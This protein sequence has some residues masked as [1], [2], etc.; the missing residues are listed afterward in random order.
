M[1]ISMNNTRK[2]IAALVFLTGFTAQAQVTLQNF[3]S[4]VGANTFFHGSWEATG[5]T[6]GT[7]SPNSQFVQGSGVYDF[8]GSAPIIPTNS[9]DSKIEFF[10]SSPV[11]IGPN[12]QLSVTAQ[13]LSGNV[14]TSFAV[15][16]FDT[17][18]K[19]ASASFATS[20]FNGGNYATATLSLTFQSGFNSS[21]IDSMIISGAQPGAIDAF[22]MSFDN[23]GVVPEPATYAAI[24]GSAAL[25]LAYLR[26]RKLKP[27][28]NP[29]ANKAD[30][31][32]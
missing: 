4:V 31:G 17:N 32:E 19:S 9:A 26:R 7:N 21:V 2:V 23:V 10:N 6:G 22:K 3:S 12:T 24:V 20:L 25:G 13:T 8:T 14:A 16:L 29:A 1:K 30:S 28:N 18:G 15:F 5:N 27:A 11:S